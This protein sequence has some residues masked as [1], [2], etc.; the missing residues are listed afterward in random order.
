MSREDRWSREQ[1]APPG[2]GS[3]NETGVTIAPTSPEAQSTAHY[4][5]RRL[6]GRSTAREGVFVFKRGQPRSTG[7]TSASAGLSMKVHAS[8]K[9]QSPFSSFAGR[10]HALLCTS[11]VLSDRRA[12]AEQDSHHLKFSTSA[13]PSSTLPRVSSLGTPFAHTVV[14]HFEFVHHLGHIRKED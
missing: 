8:G 10:M 7:S 3:N 14:E 11:A 6:L 1:Q 9:V 2:G 5:F 12:H 13:I 4:T